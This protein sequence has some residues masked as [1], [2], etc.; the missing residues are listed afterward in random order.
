[1]RVIDR[2]GLIR[3]RQGLTNA[4]YLRAVRKEPRL[5][6][7]LEC[8]V[9]AFDET[10]FGRREASAELFEDCLRHYQAGFRA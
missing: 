5:R 7:E 1:M 10:H 2:R 3:H 6:S 4:D 8:I 9:L